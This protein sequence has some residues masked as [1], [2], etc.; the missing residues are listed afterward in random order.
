MQEE[1]KIKVHAPKAVMKI[2]KYWVNGVEKYR[3]TMTM[4]TFDTYED[5]E[6][7]IKDTLILGEEGNE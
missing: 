6:K 3:V 2:D 5:A 7:L 4:G 1:P